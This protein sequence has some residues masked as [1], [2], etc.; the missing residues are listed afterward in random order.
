MAVSM[1]AGFMRS[2]Y[3]ISDAAL[4]IRMEEL[5]QSEQFSK[6][7]GELGGA[8]EQGHES[9]APDVQPTAQQDFSV[10]EQ[11]S[12]PV[13][14]DKAEVKALAKAVVRGEVKLDEI[15][16]ELVSDILLQTIAAMTAE[17]PHTEVAEPETDFAEVAPII[18]EPPQPDSEQE[19]ALVSAQAQQETVPEA[20]EKPEAEVKIEVKTEVKAEQRVEV[21]AE[22]K[23][24]VKVEAEAEVRIEN[25]PKTEAENKAEPEAEQAEKQSDSHNEV[26]SAN[27]AYAVNEAAQTNAS[28]HTQR[29]TDKPEAPKT[30]PIK[31]AAVQTE[32]AEPQ[33]MVNRT[34]S[35]S[36]QDSGTQQSGTQSAAARTADISQ[37]I[38]TN[39]DF[40]EEL[41]QLK[42]A[43]TDYSVKDLEPKKQ[44]Y[45]VRQL[46]V[47]DGS[48]KSRVVSKSDELMLLKNSAKPAADAE[49]TEQP[50]GIERSAEQLPIVFARADGTEIE[51]QPEEVV[52]QVAEDIITQAP[53]AEEGGTEYSVTLNPEDLGSITVKLTKA[54]DGSLSVSIM[55]DNAKT[56]RIIEQ[57][58]AAIQQELK[59]NGIEL[60]EWQTVGESQHEN[61][62]EDYN[63]SSKNPYYR[64][65][66]NSDSGDDEDNSFAELI[67]AM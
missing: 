58:G 28:E 27:V 7:L 57:N 41:N 59:S 48:A 60:A 29:P 16:E 5:E 3:M 18:T 9:K 15:P 54:V 44:D 53:A 23:T 22:T 55:A 40:G 38:K 66:D 10:A 45:D 6:I 52:H 37:P 34:A 61:R 2:D 56:Q 13:V 1:N 36:Q 39:D 49:V 21:K 25:E 24:E 43:I 33:Q 62:A 14:Y 19:S 51:V 63:G 47:A 65:E 17:A 67:S 50:I 4:P 46:T 20:K 26:I 12:A 32:T 42:R 35:S 8:L 30:E 31:A 64:G 11:Q